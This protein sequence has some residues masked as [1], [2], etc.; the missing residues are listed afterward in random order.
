MALAQRCD[1]NN[2]IYAMLRRS[3]LLHERGTIC[4]LVMCRTASQRVCNC[5]W[6]VLCER[7]APQ[8]GLRQEQIR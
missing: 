3:S 8:H 5:D 2:D 7:N 1:A 6:V 4:F